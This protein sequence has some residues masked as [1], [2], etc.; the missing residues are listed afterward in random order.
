MQRNRLSSF[1]VPWILIAALTLSPLMAQDQQASQVKIVELEGSGASGATEHVDT[2]VVG[3]AILSALPS[4]EAVAQAAAAAALPVGPGANASETKP[5]G[6]TKS[7]IIAALILT[8]AVV[9][10]LLAL[11]GRNGN[12]SSATAAPVGPAPA[13]AT[14]LAPGTPRVD[15]PK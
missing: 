1:G 7:T 14:V 12:T 8:G 10:I 9:G 11:K 6:K 13:E 15:T 2:S 3:T 5:P 4:K